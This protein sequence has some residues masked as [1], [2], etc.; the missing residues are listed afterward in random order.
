MGDKDGDVPERWRPFHSEHPNAA[1]LELDNME[2]QYFVESLQKL[3]P[4]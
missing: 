3:V 4:N 1:D 2:L